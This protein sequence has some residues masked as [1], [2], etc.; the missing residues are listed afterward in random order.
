MTSILSPL[1]TTKDFGYFLPRFHKA[2]NV[3]LAQTHLVHTVLKHRHGIGRINV[4]VF[5]FI[6]PCQCKKDFQ[7]V[8]FTRVRGYPEYLID[9][10]HSGFVLLF[11]AGGF[12]FH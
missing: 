6:S 9:T 4:V 7:F 1:S 12:D 5:L 8:R 11:C 2:F 3:F 10:S